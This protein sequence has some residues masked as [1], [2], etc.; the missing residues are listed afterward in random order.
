MIYVVVINSTSAYNVRPASSKKGIRC[1]SFFFISGGDFRKAEKYSL[2]LTYTTQKPGFFLYLA[3]QLFNGS[4][5]NH[6]HLQNT[7]SATRPRPYPALPPGGS[8]IFHRK[9][10][11]TDRCLW[12]GRKI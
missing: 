3:S 9:G 12:Q 1:R 4:T 6:A 11:S 5:Q 8:P 2:P 7:A 10:R